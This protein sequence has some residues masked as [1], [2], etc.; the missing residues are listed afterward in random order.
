MGTARIKLNVDEF[1]LTE[2]SLTFDSFNSVVLL[3][4][5]NICSLEKE[6][7]S[8]CGLTRQ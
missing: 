4:L 5:T 1:T 8:A 7:P 3:H 2:S 6:Q